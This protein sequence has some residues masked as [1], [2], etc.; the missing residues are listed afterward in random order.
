MLAAKLAQADH[1]VYYINL[2][3]IDIEVNRLYIETSLNRTFLHVRL[4]LTT[5]MHVFSL[6]SSG[7]LHHN[8]RLIF[9]VYAKK[10]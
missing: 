1:Y 6:L 10:F 4:R 9:S 7:L 5:D 3:H 8:M 2:V